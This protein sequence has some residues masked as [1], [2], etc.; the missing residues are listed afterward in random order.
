LGEGTNRQEPADVRS[1]LI[2]ALIIGLPF[3]VLTPRIAPAVGAIGLVAALALSFNELA[4]VDRTAFISI[5][6][7]V[8]AVALLGLALPSRL[9][10]VLDEAAAIFLGLFAV[11]PGSFVPWWWRI[12]LRRPKLA[13]A[14]KLASQIG[15]VNRL[16]AEALIGKDRGGRALALVEEQIDRLRSLPAPDPDWAQLRNDYA[17]ECATIVE[18]GWR[19][20]VAQEHRDETAH[21]GALRARFDELFARG[22]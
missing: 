5:A 12:A 1:G 7:P 20:A 21:A 17:D 8:G 9:A 6:I 4:R 16:T 18:L 2:V 11:A 3:A 22:G 13:F 15:E 14:L 10:V 19:S